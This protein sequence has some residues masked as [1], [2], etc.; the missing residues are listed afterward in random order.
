MVSLKRE[1]EKQFSTFAQIANGDLDRWIEE[2]RLKKSMEKEQL[3]LQW[4]LG[5]SFPVN[6]WVSHWHHQWKSQETERP[7]YHLQAYLQEPCYWAAQKISSRFN[8]TNFGLADCFQTAFEKSN[9]VLERFKPELGTSLSTYAGRAF[10]N[11]IQDALGQY[12]EVQIS[13]ELSLLQRCGSKRLGQALIAAGLSPEMQSLHKAAWQSFKSF[14]FPQ[15]T[16]AR[17]LTSLAPEDWAMMLAH[18]EVLRSE[19]NL[20]LASEAQLHEWLVNC[21]LHLR[22]YTTPQAISLNASME[23]SEE[24]L[25]QLGDTRE[26]SI[27]LL[28][29]QEQEADRLQQQQTITTVLVAGLSKLKPL[30]QQL[31]KLYYG[32]GLKQTEIAERLNSQQCTVSRQLRAS[33]QALLKVLVTWIL[34]ELHISCETAVLNNMTVILE[35]WL[36]V[37]FSGERN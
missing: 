15:A 14:Y 31:L 19:Q 16:T 12:N 27:A 34:E 17:N 22:R 8:T 3:L 37:Q 23:D 1:K 7:L 4:E 26:E 5:K 25:E 30:N 35:D 10:S 24:F 13:S 36:K 18:Y 29:A 21:V 6:A 11:A 28:L 33:R 9:T 32:E 20:D 2:P